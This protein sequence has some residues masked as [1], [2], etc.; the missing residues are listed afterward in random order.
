MEE[1]TSCNGVFEKLP[2]ILSSWI[3]WD[4]PDLN[5]RRIATKK[6]NDLRNGK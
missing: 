6:R 5:S 1:N 2:V 3:S 4:W